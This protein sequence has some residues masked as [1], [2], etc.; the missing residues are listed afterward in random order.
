MTKWIV[1]LLAGLGINNVY[2]TNFE[3]TEM[4]QKNTYIGEDGWEYM[5]SLPEVTMRT[6]TPEDEAYFV[7]LIRDMFNKAIAPADVANKLGPV[8]SIN[9]HSIAFYPY[10]SNFG[11]S[12]IKYPNV[13]TTI[14]DHNAYQ[15]ETVV[16]KLSIPRGSAFRTLG[17]E[18]FEKL[19]SVSIYVKEPPRGYDGSISINSP[20]F[21]Y[22]GRI[23]I[24]TDKPWRLPDAEIVAINIFVTMPYEKPQG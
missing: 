5:T 20:N 19:F 6:M 24:S 17:P 2:A 14:D 3:T 21:K 18:F 16:L 15:N 8:E 13:T 22:R 10:N 23:S 12:F 9:N 4:I 11:L 1:T 7:T